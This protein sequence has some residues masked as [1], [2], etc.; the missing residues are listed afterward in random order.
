MWFPLIYHS[1]VELAPR[2]H[3][4]LL[5]ALQKLCVVLVCESYNKTGRTAAHA[6]LVCTL[7]RST[8]SVSFSHR[9]GITAQTNST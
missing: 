1:D 5:L 4:P 2:N 8:A 7:S 9:R 6:L 3:C